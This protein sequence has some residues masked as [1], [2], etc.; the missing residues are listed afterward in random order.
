MAKTFGQTVPLE[1]PQDTGTPTSASSDHLPI[2]RLR[3]GRFNLVALL[4]GAVLSLFWIG[5]S[6]AFL[7]GYLGPQG[8][9]ALDP[10]RKALVAAGVLLP[11]LLFL[12]IAA[13]LA[14]ASAMEGATKVLLAASDRLFAADEITANN[15][16]RLARAVRRELDGLNTDWMSPSSACAP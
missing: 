7:W 5:V 3:S 1:K 15:A 16:A 6:A 11:P 2:P 4:A 9:V 10:A 14:R 12:S 13:V 8:L